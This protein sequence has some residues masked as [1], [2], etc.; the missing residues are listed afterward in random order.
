MVVVLGRPSLAEPAN[1]TVDAAGVLARAMPG[2]RFLS[3]LRRGNVHGA[4]D[5][6]LAPGILPGRVSLDDGRARFASAVGPGPRP[7]AASTP[8]ASSRAAADGR[9]EALVLLGADPRRTS[10]TATWPGGRWPRS[11]SPSPWTRS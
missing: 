11:P 4:L 5:M 3:A 2:A 7:A 6:G 8:R 9:I 10:P 1:A